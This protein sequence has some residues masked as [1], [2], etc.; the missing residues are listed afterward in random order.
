MD[1][2]QAITVTPESA[3]SSRGKIRELSTKVHHD[4]NE[5]TFARIVQPQVGAILRAPS[6][7]T[8]TLTF[9]LSVVRMLIRMDRSMHG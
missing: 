9:P 1:K 6:C 8:L 5:V 7:Y 4:G 2:I 3:A